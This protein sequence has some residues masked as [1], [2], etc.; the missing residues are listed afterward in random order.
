MRLGGVL[1][2]V[3]I[4]LVGSSVATPGHAQPADAW[5]AYGVERVATGGSGDYAGWHDQLVASGRYEIAA[6]PDAEHVRVHGVYQWRY[7]SSESVDSGSEDRT[8]PV[9]VAT[10]TYDGERTDLDEYDG[11]AASTLATW[12]WIPV[13]VATGDH[14]RVLD[15]DF[16]ADV[17][18]ETR[19]AGME[20]PAIH[21]VAS[22]DGT[23]SDEYGSFTTHYTDEYWFD[24]ATGM[25]L[26]EHRVETDTGT[27]GTL[28][29]D[30]NVVVEDASYAARVGLP[31]VDPLTRPPP[32]FRRDDPA[33]QFVL[34]LGLCVA[35]LVA[36]AVWWVLR[37]RPPTTRAIVLNEIRSRAELPALPADVSLNFGP[38]LAHFVDVARRIGSPVWTAS[39]DDTVV[40]LAI[41]D[42]PTRIPTIFAR[43]A[44]ACE[45]LRRQLGRLDFFSEVRHGNLRSVV[46]A[47]VATG[48][49]LP[50]STAYNVLETYEV[51][52]LKEP[53][54]P[55]Y[56][57]SVVSRLEDE[58]IAEAASLL[59][60]VLG[61]PCEDYL[62]AALA[63][64]DVAYA[65]RAEGRIVGV[66]LATVLGVEGRLHT[67]AVHPSHRNRGL[68]RELVR[69]RIRAMSALG[70]TR[71]VTE[72]AATNAASLELARGEG[73]VS[74][75]QMYVETSR[76]TKTGAPVPTVRR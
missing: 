73:F 1:A 33:F 50:A 39:V 24:A 2:A 34:P 70:A 21:L 6:L 45:R 35:F 54:S 43:D 55:A 25:F 60:Q 68:G 75:G 26:R 37:G 41:D 44:D 22:G 59:T 49:K 14:V 47:T 20:R 66:G 36:L 46:E 52:R 38:F 65:A 16:V 53:G 8:V 31:V 28:L 11:Q 30:E 17:G 48:E 57:T 61:A 76:E 67:L 62:K 32:H 27:S 18:D 3:V 74:V 5:F 29:F 42:T 9:L 12:V 69:A 64:G 10:R 63:A 71:I 19:A 56:D 13:G 40:G 7:T 51:L 23:R 4:G 15:D 58:G 72:I